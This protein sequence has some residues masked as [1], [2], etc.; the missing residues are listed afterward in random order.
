MRSARWIA[1]GSFA[2]VFACQEP[3]KAR[4]PGLLDQSGRPATSP[5]DVAAAPEA[6]QPQAPQFDDL[7]PAGNPNQARQDTASG[8]SEAAKQVAALAEP[9]ATNPVR[10]LAA[11]LLSLFPPPATCLDLALATRSAGPLVVSAEAM[12]MPSGRIT[13]VSAQA[14]GQSSHNL[15]CIEAYIGQRSLA[16]DVPEAPVLVRASLPLEVVAEEK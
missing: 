5:R 15:R 16:S 1:W 8:I 10:D 12:I 11:E 7:T 4:P 13:R 2:L 3:E 6:P 14:T 9:E